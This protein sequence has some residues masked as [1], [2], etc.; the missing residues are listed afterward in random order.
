MCVLITL[1]FS[2]L[3]DCSAQTA[4]PQVRVSIDTNQ[5]YWV[6]QKIPFYVDL[7][8]P[9]F[10]TGTP[11]FDLPEISGVLIMKLPERPVM[12]TEEIEGHSFSKQ[13]HEF[14]FFPQRPGQIVFPSFSVRFGVSEQAGEPSKEYTLKTS[15]LSLTPKMPP[16]AQTLGTII[17]TRDLKVTEKWNPTPK[18][19]ETGNAFIRTVTF[20]APDIP[21]MAFPPMPESRIPGIGIY[22][23]PPVVNDRIERGA[24]FGE[25]TEKV[26]YVMESPG[27]LVIPAL[28][29]HWFDIKSETLK[30]EQLPEVTFN[31]T[32]S[33]PGRSSE[34]IESVGSFKKLFV[35]LIVLMIIIVSILWIWRKYLT[36][37]VTSWRK[38]KAQSESRY[39]KK[40]TGA[41]SHD[42]PAAALNTLMAWVDRVNPDRQT[43]TLKQFSE[44]W[45]DPELT[46]EVAALQKA[47]FFQESEFST[48]K[49][50]GAWSGRNLSRLVI[51]ARKQLIKTKYIQERVDGELMPLNPT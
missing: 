24:F 35:V 30:S 42:N 47:S 15:P 23:K 26:T 43:A 51:T 9:V 13:R 17:S 50:K 46:Y 31:V 41:C 6:G 29:F 14:A 8:S 27:K 33:S 28:S 2:L 18:D 39:F 19:S 48:E 10:F 16:G 44:K 5:S 11:K 49:M 34:T 45:G 3:P 36:S 25:R 22:P 1:T 4:S 12:G 20:H 40:F 32:P 37:Y 7:L 21:G 38:Y